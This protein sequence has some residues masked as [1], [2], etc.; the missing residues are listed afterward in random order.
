MKNEDM[1]EKLVLEAFERGK[2]FG[3]AEGRKSIKAEMDKLKNENDFFKSILNDVELLKKD[4][5]K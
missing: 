4:K 2:M 3:Y 5:E 1:N